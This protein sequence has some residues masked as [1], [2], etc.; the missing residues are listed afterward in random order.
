M[1]NVSVLFYPN[2][3]AYTNL[4]NTVYYN[5]FPHFNG[6]LNLYQNINFQGNEKY[7]IILGQ[8]I[9]GRFEVVIVTTPKNKTSGAILPFQTFYTNTSVQIDFSHSEDIVTPLAPGI[10][11]LIVIIIV[12]VV[13]AIVIVSIVLVCRGKGGKGGK[14]DDS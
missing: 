6:I 1:F 10:I 11:A 9:T 8:N 14:D 4:N 5:V 7:D 2:S 3:T 13:A 12:V